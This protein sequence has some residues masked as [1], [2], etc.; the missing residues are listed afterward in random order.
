MVIT[1]DDLPCANCADGSWGT[2]TTE[3]LDVLG[4]HR[5]PAIGFVNEGKLYRDGVLD[6][7][8]LVLLE[9]WLRRGQDLGNHT[10]AHKGTDGQTV[11]EYGDDI[12]RGERSL[13]P[14]MKKHG[15]ELRYFRHPFLR[16]GHAP[17]Y[18]DSLNAVIAK[19]GYTVAPVTLDNDE[20]VYAFCYEHAQRANDTALMSALATGYLMY[21]DSVIRFHEDQTKEFLGRA[22]PQI[23]LIHANALNADNLGDLLDR[24]EQRG[25]RFVP[26]EE[27]LADE[28]YNLPE[29]TTQYGFS[30]IRRWRLAAGQDP[31]WPPEVDAGV[32]ERYEKLRKH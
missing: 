7:T 27:A 25:Y 1:I 29:S 5:V 21:M 11:A 18:R 31:P 30:W 2:V 32:M 14:L 20:Y 3:L 10:Y 28:A 9:E 23:L 16:T 24:L 15:K 26:L 22:I 12:M 13:R 4:S 6:S 8:R 19:L 17:S